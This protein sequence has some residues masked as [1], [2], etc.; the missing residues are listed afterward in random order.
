MRAAF[1]LLVREDVALN[2][3]A[4]AQNGVREL[5]ALQRAQGRKP[6]ELSVVIVVGE[7]DVGPHQRL[8]GELWMPGDHKG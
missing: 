5:G 4:H 2:R 8:P 7:H 3:S 1:A 6:F